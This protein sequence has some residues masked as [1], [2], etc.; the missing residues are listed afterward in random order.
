M[1]TDRDVNPAK[2]FRDRR[3][4]TSWTRLHG[5]VPICNDFEVAHRLRAEV[6]ARFPE[7]GP[8]ETFDRT[9]RYV[10]AYCRTAV[11]CLVAG[12][13]LRIFLPLCDLTFTNDWH[14]QLSD[15][16]GVLAAEAAEAAE[17]DLSPEKF[18]C[19]AGILCT[20]PAHPTGCG[21]AML[22]TYRYLVE[23]SLRH[24]PTP[25]AEFLLNRRDHPLVRAPPRRHPY[26]AVW[27]GPAPLLPGEFR[28]G[29]LLP[30]LSPYTGPG[31]ED[32]LIP[33]AHDVE[34]LTGRVFPS[35]D[36]SHEPPVLHPPT[37]PWSHRAPRAFFRGTATSAVRRRLVEDFGSDGRF[38]V[39]LTGSSRR[40]FVTDGTAWRPPPVDTRARR[41]PPSEW[42]RY[43]VLLA[44]DGH[45]GLNRWAA[46]AAAGGHVV[47]V[48]DPATAAPDCFLAQHIPHRVC[49][50]DDLPDVVSDLCLTPPRRVHLTPSLL[51]SG[52]AAAMGGNLH[53]PK[54]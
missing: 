16:D 9:L 40:I 12:G 10:Q 31:F 48:R 2:A 51:W 23:Q 22:S 18:W 36:E 52:A 53:E 26:A 17:A 20:R 30:V 28:D 49:D 1:W 44:P 15:P 37:L 33:T 32:R 27:S 45:S 3:S 24:H 50:V 47:R 25:T 5:P 35:R 43:R 6:A 39:G 14:A 13:R 19:N 46:L 11:Y 34:A 41:V 29:A 8:S 21:D 42:G 4:A 38:D 7:V 54:E